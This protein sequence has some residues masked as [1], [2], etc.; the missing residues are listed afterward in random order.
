MIG[1]EKGRQAS[2]RGNGGQKLGGRM[3]KAKFSNRRNNVGGESGRNRKQDWKQGCE[4][5]ALQGPRQ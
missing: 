3:G 5:G 1:I 2:G 4:W